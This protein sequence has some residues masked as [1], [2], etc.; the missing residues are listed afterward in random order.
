MDAAPALWTRE[1]QAWLGVL[2]HV[3]LVPGSVAD[4]A[5]A[6]VADVP[7]VPVGAIERGSGRPPA[8]AQDAPALPAAR[9]DTPVRRAPPMSPVQ[10]GPAAPAVAS[11]RAPRGRLLPDALQLALIRASGRDPNAP[12]MAE[13][14]ASWPASA[15][16]RADP[17]AKRA[18][19]PRLRALRRPAGG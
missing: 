8:R 4:A 16:L 6:P 17:A 19:W 15:V 11:A 12:G 5:A 3:V 13:E 14:M 18:L 10:P 9:D 1:Q 2:G 7:A